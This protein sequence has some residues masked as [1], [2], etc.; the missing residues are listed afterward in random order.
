[1][2]HNSILSPFTAA[3][4]E[5]IALHDWPLPEIWPDQ[6]I[7]G[8]VIISHGLGE[9]ALRYTRVAEQLNSWG[10]HVRAYDLYGHGESGGRPGSLPSEMR[11]VDDLVDVF[12]E[13]ERTH[14]HDVKKKI[15]LFGHSMGGV[16]SASLVRQ[17]LRPVDG[18][19]LSSPALN[20]GLSAFQK[21]L[22]GT[23]PKFV[24]NLRVDNGLKVNRLCRD[25]AVVE[26]YKRDSFVHRK[27]SARLAQFIATEGQACIDAAPSWD[28]PTLLLY[29]GSD[30]LVSPEGSRAFAAAAPKAMLQAQCFEAMD[31]E[32]LNDP[33]KKQVFEVMQR[34]LEAQTA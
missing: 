17:K 23:L 18:L 13:T 6:A 4:G 29:A 19:I 28:V 15:Y 27:V 31:H 30:V 33:D 7:F 14:G 1:M 12:D 34:W 10:Y 3:D 24:P 20:P 21:I 22:L 5:N 25:P 16:V 9:H 8:T 26:A 11:L 2:E 32:I